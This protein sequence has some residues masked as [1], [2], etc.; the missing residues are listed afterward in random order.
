MK[1]AVFSDVHGNRHALEMVLQDIAVRNPDLTVCLGDLVGYNAFPSEVVRLIRENGIATVMG[2]YDDA[3]A[4]SRMVCGCDYKDVKAAELGIKS[5]TWT[6][7]NTGPEEKEFLRSLPDKL[8]SKLGGYQVLFVHGS[9]RKLNEYLFEDTTAG[10]VLAMMQDASADVLICGHTHL[11]YHRVIEGR[12]VINVGSVGKPK[13]G[14]PDAVYALVEFNGG[15]QTK[16]IKVPYDHE[17]AA[18]AVENA[19]L[20]KEFAAILRTGRG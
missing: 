17:A 8:L 4:N 2:N 13:H 12:H 10:D 16:F 19:G 11:P 7:E 3:I 1:I 18:R 14:D 5:I 6:V 15:V 9:P 20:P